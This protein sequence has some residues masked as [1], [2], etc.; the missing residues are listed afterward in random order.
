MDELSGPEPPEQIRHVRADALARAEAAWRARVA[1]ATWAQAAEI[2]G[3]KDRDS[4]NRQVK[5]VYG[6]LP[7][8]DRNE[9]RN[10][11]RDRL[12]VMWRQSQLDMREQRAGAVTAAVRV[13]TAAAAL[14]GLADPVK[15]DVQTSLTFDAL[16]GLVERHG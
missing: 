1:G 14:D 15:V 8:V 11:W 3:Y 4:C 9:L 6:Q 5:R 2:A 12:E 10:L 13:T 16:V 7:P